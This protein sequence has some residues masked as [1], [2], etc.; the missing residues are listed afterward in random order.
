MLKRIHEHTFDEVA[1]AEIQ[2][3]EK[4]R[5]ARGRTSKT[6]VG[7]AIS[8]GGIR[9]ASFAMGVLQGLHRYGLLKCVDYLSSVSGG[10]YISSSLTWFNHL[11]RESDPEF[12]FGTRGIGS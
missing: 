8:G 6:W 7:L 2:R 9:S 4:H 3:I 10:S 11:Q 12:P 5:E 1:D